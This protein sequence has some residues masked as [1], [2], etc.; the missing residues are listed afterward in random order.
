LPRLESRL[1][2]TAKLTQALSTLPIL[3][4]NSAVLLD[5]Y[6]GAIDQL[7]SDIDQ[8]QSYVYVLYYIFADDAT[9]RRVAQALGHAA[10]RG[11]ICDVLLDGPGSR[12]YLKRIMPEPH[13]AGVQAHAIAP[14]SLA[15]VF[16]RSRTSRIDLRNH[17][18]IVVIDGLIGY[19]GWSPRPPTSSWSARPSGPSTPSSSR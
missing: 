18:K 15:H 5:D 17:R 9:G 4:G 19:T 13:A 14:P 6:Q 1:W 7:I 11:V 16:A 3:D 12:R 10:T 8:A 2:S